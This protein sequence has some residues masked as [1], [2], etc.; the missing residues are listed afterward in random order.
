M[1]N[2]IKI[3]LDNRELGGVPPTAEL[4][5]GV[6]RVWGLR[7]RFGRHRPKALPAPA[8]ESSRESY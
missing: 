3:R 6:R 4:T 1:R 8:I 2:L 7:S 5:T